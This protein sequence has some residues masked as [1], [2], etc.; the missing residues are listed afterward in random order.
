MTS[1]EYVK[2]ITKK[3]EIVL[4][5]KNSYLYKR[6]DEMKLTLSVFIT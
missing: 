4:T 1:C 5:L 3:G 6:E 2:N